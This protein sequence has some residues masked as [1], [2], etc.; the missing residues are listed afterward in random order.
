MEPIN[1][2]YLETITKM[3]STKCF[4]DYIQ[5][6]HFGHFLEPESWV[7]EWINRWTINLSSENKSKIWMGFRN[8]LLTRSKS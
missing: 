5:C 7:E 1:S 6:S 2:E 8:Q 4:F 3:L